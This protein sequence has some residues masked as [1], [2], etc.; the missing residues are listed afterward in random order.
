MERV[1][2]NLYRQLM[3]LRP[4]MA[5]A[6]QKVYDAWDQGEDCDY[7]EGGIC[8]EIASEISGIIVSHIRD[9]NTT[10][11]GQDGDD[12]AWTVVYN[13]TESYGVDIP[14]QVYETGSGYCWHK[15]P[16]VTFE[17]NDVEIWNL[18][19]HPREFEQN[20]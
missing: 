6:A 19:I 7:G 20:W 16:D 17:P 13:Q 4:L 9:V 10:D 2:S 5:Q 3:A 8:D 11:G 15:I 14:P 18:G 1:Q 12:H